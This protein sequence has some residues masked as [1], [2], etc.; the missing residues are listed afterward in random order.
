MDV[1]EPKKKKP[2]RPKKHKKNEPEQP[3]NYV[4]SSCQVLRNHTNAE[5]H[6]FSSG[7]GFYCK[8]CQIKTEIHIRLSR[9]FT[10]KG[11]STGL[12]LVGPT[13]VKACKSFLFTEGSLKLISGCVYPYSQ[14]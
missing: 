6:F 1:S 9:C 13:K 10:A 5:I 11:S 7:R 2:G 3:E 14:G 8:I 4:S 12:S